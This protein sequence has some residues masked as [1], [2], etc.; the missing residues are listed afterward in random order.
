MLPIY[1]LIF[2]LLEKHEKSRSV[3]PTDIK[4]IENQPEPVTKASHLPTVTNPPACPEEEAMEVED[5]EDDDDDL[6]A[7]MRRYKEEKVKERQ[8]PQSSL[9]LL[10]DSYGGNKSQARYHI[11]I[12]YAFQFSGTYSLK[13]SII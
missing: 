5:E 13:Q 9:S 11:I 12:L 3:S 1:F 4:L 6:E 8:E 7:M 2:S 10:M